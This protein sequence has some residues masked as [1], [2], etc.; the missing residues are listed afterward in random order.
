MTRPTRF[1]VVLDSDSTLIENEVIELLADAAGSLELVAAV[2]EQ[3]MRGE[4]DFAESL[5]ARVKTLAGLPESV[6]TDVGLLVRPTPGVHELIAGLHAH[7]SRIGVVSGGFHEVLDPLAESLGID[8]WR[9]N[10]LEVVGGHLTGNLVGPIIDAT[11][12]ADTLQE[13]AAE[14]GVALPQTVA[15]GDGAN[16]LKMMHVAGLGIAF[17][18]K[19]LVRAQ[20]D[21]AIDICDLSQ[22]LP[23]L[24]LRG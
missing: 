7:G 1:L 3:A 14:L 21:V 6:F 16:D 2:T 18:A 5:R 22:V 8:H 10:R 17:N 24:G 9:A 20:A 15:V 19:P 23:I 4:I 12:K 13:W 11:A